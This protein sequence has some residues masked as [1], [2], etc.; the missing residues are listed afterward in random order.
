MLLWPTPTVACATGGQT[1]RGGD[2]KDELL[3]AGMV[4]GPLNADWV[5]A[6]VGFPPGW[7][8]LAE[9]EMSPLLAKRSR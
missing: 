9:A 6:L 7:T 5:E 8:T 3:L 1:C 2:R 4:G